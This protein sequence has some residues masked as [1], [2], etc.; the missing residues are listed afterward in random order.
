[1]TV[2]PH[3]GRLVGASNPRTH[4]HADTETEPMV[5]VTAPAMSL[6]ASG[7][8]GG[9]MTFSKWKG[10]NYVRQLVRPANP[11]SAG[12][13]YNRAFFKFLAQTWASIKTLYASSWQ[14]LADVD[15]VSPFNAFVK[16]A[17]QDWQ[18]D[19]NPVPDPATARSTDPTQSEPAVCTGGVRRADIAVSQV[20][21]SSSWG[22]ILYRKLAG[23]PTGASTEVIAVL[24]GVSAG[25]NYIDSG[26][27]AGTYHYK[28]R[29]FDIDGKMYALSN[30]ANAVVT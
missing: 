6:D 12:Q 9:T 8:I 28:V 27:E 24:E 25:A 2:H 19:L 4:K 18:S 13:T 1:M 21:A 14:A 10:R 17:M 22:Y 30:D 11:R 16:Q 5:K 7:S 29:Q 15:K 3:R 23:A 20:A 26:L